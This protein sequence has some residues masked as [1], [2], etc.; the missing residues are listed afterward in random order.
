MCDD[1]CG[2]CFSS[3]EKSKLSKIG[4][5]NEQIHFAEHSIIEDK[6]KSLI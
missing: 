1:G 6:I 2:E 5:S 4:W 3:E